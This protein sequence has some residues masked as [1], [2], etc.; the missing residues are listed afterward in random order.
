M[1]SVW[2]CCRR[3]C[4]IEES[5]LVTI[6]AT[7][8]VQ[9]KNRVKL[10][11]NGYH[12]RT[13]SAGSFLW[14]VLHAVKYGRE[15]SVGAFPRCLMGIA[16][17]KGHDKIVEHPLKLEIS[18]RA[19]LVRFCLFFCRVP[20]QIRYSIKLRKPYLWWW[21]TRI[22]NERLK[23]KGGKVSWIKVL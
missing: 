18:E 9:M 10:L 6:S 19:W 7:I 17:Y 2:K 5:D 20:I 3:P 23:P 1:G 12:A 21:Y 13:K 15:S 14:R 11:A 8:T 22:G 16:I 4:F